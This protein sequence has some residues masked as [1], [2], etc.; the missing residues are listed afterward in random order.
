MKNGK[1]MVVV[2]HTSFVSV[3]DLKKFFSEKLPNV[4]VHH[5]VDDSLLAEVMQ[6][7]G[8]T[9]FIVRRVCAYAEFAEE[10]GADLIFNQCSSVGEAINVARNLVSIPITK[11][12]EPMAEKA[13]AS[14][15][16]IAVIATVASTMKPSVGLIYE[17][18]EKASKEV[19]VLECLVD[20]ALDVLMKEGDKKKH[21][22][23]VL[24]E[25]DRVS[26]D[27]DV[28]VLAQ[29]SMLVLKPHLKDVGVPILTSPEAG[30]ERAAEILERLN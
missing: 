19:E 24:N 6:N 21:N 14:G 18:A 7:G 22:Q 20:G 25:I 29:G 3:D 1:K 17:A 28:I 30:V 16:R 8:I 13:V 26:K 10:M 27:C 15:K 11:V 23:L 4:L 9:P 12:D 5:I 2:I